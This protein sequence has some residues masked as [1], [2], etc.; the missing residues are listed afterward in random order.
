[1]PKKIVGTA[2]DGKFNCKLLPFE[3]ENLLTAQEVQ[4]HIGWEIT[5]FN[6]PAAWKHTQG[7]GVKVAVI[8]SGADLTHHDLVDNL[9][10]GRNFVDPTKSAQD[11]NGHG[12][13]SPDCLIH[14]SVN[15]IERIEDFYNNLDATESVVSNKEGEYRIKN[16]LALTYSLDD[17]THKTVVGKI[18]S[19]QK[20]PICGNIVEVELEGNIIYRLTPWHP[21]YLIKNRHHKIYDIIRKRADEVVPGDRFIFGQKNGPDITTE[22]TFVNLPETTIC[23]NCGHIPRWKKASGGQCKKCNRRKWG[24]KTKN[25]EVTKNL[26]YLCGITLT[27][28]HICKDRFEVS[29]CTMEILDRVEHIAK[30]MGWT[31]GRYENRI[32]VY[33]KEA[34][35]TITAMGVMRGK[36]SLVQDL[37]T[38]VG[39]C[40]RDITYGFL[41]GVIDGDGSVTKS[42]VKNRITTGSRCFAYKTAALMN[43]LGI[44]SSVSSPEFDNRDRSIKSN[45]PVFKICH[46][47][48]PMAVIESLCHPVKTKRSLI[49]PNYER[50]GRRVKKISQKHYNGWVYDFTVSDHHNYIADGHFVSNTHVTGIICAA[51]NDFGMVG[52]A[53]KCKVIP[54]KALNHKGAG[55]L[56]VVADAIRWAVDQGADFLTM[57][58]GSPNPVIQIRKAIQYADAYGVIVFCAA[59]NAG[60]TREIFYPAAYPETIGVGAID[61]NFNRASFSC[62]GPDLDFLAPGVRILSTVP[63][64]WY[65]LMSG[66]SQANPFVVGV[67][68]LML[69]YKRAHGLPLKLETSEDYRRLLRTY[70]IPTNDPK[71][72]GN[73]FFEG[74]GIIDPRKFEEWVTLNQQSLNQRAIVAEVIR[75]TS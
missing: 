21:V 22:K 57:S 39:K 67:A 38:W 43:A 10:P 33:G 49:V 65:A 11:D 48:V 40:N 46:G 26:A 52:V 54:V 61:E 15:G 59:G 14:T 50:H 62:T 4:K 71:F 37:P 6:L 17:T 20:L 69:S 58:L 34:V 63:G 24:K 25:V 42:N 19:V 36:K 3:R 8:D 72:V 66:T 16:V 75:L 13:V 27:D 73:K 45:M 32:L 28:G 47:A 29:S 7:E 51:N 9:L 64:N 12:C 74:F 41:A 35:H 70:T 68:A 30:K 2:L 55:D 31:T 5:A 18:T 1:M 53:P 56:R 60:Q 23:L 44:R